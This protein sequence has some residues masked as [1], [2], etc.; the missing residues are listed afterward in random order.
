MSELTPDFT[1]KKHLKNYSELGIRPSNS[2]EYSAQI[3][4]LGRIPST[5]Y[6][7]E[8]SEDIR[9]F[10]AFGTPLH[11]L[12]ML[13]KACT[14]LLHLVHACYSL[15]TP[16]TA[17]ARLLQLVHACYSLYTL[18]TACTYLL[19]LVHACCSLLTLA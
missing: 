6:S 1:K 17:S 13:V 3:F 12:Y 11:S 18:V 7:A 10:R 9:Q 14:R 2:A 19:Q 15:Y 16:A 5:R 4:L 8:Y